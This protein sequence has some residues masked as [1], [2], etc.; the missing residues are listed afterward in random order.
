MG[1]DATPHE[2]WQRMSGSKDKGFAAA[3]RMRTGEAAVAVVAG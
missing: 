1:A 3:N 2:L